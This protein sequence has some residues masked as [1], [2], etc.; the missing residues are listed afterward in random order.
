MIHEMK[1]QSKYYDFIQNGT[2]RI[3]LRLNDEKRALINLG[4]TIKFLKL[5]ELIE[6]MEV[7]VIG[8]LRYASFAELFNDFSIDIMADKSMT[9]EEL[10]N[11]LQEFYMPEKQK[12]YG[13]L[14]IRIEKKQ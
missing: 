1:L 11:V 6:S 8:L 13:V 7:T 2:K 5:P 4:D 9:K 10:L 12:E 14:G 3:E